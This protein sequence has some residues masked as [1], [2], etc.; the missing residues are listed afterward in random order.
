[1]VSL[2]YAK[3]I[4]AKNLNCG[5]EDF[6]FFTTYKEKYSGNYLIDESMNVFLKYLLPIFGL[7]MI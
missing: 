5:Y 2:F 3:Y 1:M 7:K 6:F 4:V